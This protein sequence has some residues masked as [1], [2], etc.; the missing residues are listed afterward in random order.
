[1]PSSAPQRTSSSDT[2]EMALLAISPFGGMMNK[3]TQAISTP[4][5]NDATAKRA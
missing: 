2:I 4:Q 5:V 1:M 3:Q